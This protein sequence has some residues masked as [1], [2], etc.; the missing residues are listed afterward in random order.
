MWVHPHLAQ[1]CI[2]VIQT[3]N[4]CD[5]KTSAK[6]QSL[7]LHW[8]QKSPNKQE[9]KRL[10]SIKCINIS[11]LIE[12]QPLFIYQNNG[13]ICII[14]RYVK[15]VFY[16]Y[17]ISTT[18]VL[19]F[20]LFFFSSTLHLTLKGFLN[21]VSRLSHEHTSIQLIKNIYNAKSFIISLS[22]HVS[23]TDTVSINHIYF[24]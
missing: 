11:T 6:S 16:N 15:T 17:A 23:Y 22:F 2:P 10:V 18:L 14:W 5:Q 7:N 12:L 24:Y 13:M 8:S 21:G 9:K 1:Q 20:P 3:R 4:H 19:K